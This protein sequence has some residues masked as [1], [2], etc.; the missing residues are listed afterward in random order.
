M[1]DFQVDLPSSAKAKFIR[2]DSVKTRSEKIFILS[3][4]FSCTS[5][6]QR[7]ELLET[8]RVVNLKVGFQDE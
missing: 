1:Y 3:G 5:N 7:F 4:V 8:R 6:L 2:L